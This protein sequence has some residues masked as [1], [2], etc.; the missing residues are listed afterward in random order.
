MAPQV[1]ICFDP[2]YP[3]AAVVDYARRVERAG[4]DQLWVIEDCFRTAGVSLAA[5]AL[6]VTSR[7][8]VGFGILPAVA[9]NAAITAMEL[10]TLAELAGGRVIAG[11]GHG[12]QDWMGQMGARPTSPLTTLEEVVVAVRRLLAGE[13]VT[14]HGAHVVLERVA[15]DPPPTIP[16]PVL[17]GAQQPRSLALAGRVADGVVLVGGSGPTH[18]RTCLRHA[19]A[20]DEFRTV[21]FASLCVLPERERAHRA[22]APFVEELLRRSAPCV[23]DHPEV[24]GIRERYA[25]GGL[26]GLGT[27][28]S[29][30]WAEI[31]PIGTFADA[32]SFTESIVDAGVS[33]VAFFPGPELE[34]GLA[35]ID[36]VEQLAAAVRSGR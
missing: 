29:A 12:V 20:G 32:V 35:D 11:I 26:D 9:R 19:G 30:W 34:L 10:A 18:V 25:T 17:V 31:G 5:A 7:L 16:P 27:M 15:L 2:G 33:D 8:H 14:C 22:M 1:G 3:A 6:A 24:D 13:E 21:A 4:I 28:P 36:V 23:A